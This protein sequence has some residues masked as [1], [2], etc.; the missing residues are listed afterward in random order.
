M[1]SHPR[2]RHLDASVPKS[3]G[4]QELMVDLRMSMGCHKNNR[5]ISGGIF[6]AKKH[7]ILILMVFILSWISDFC[8]HI[9]ILVC[10]DPISVII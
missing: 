3:S 10:R 2:P 4:S 9:D 1:N 5:G 8:D 7:L 6:E